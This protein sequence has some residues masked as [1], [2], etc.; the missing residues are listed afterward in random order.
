MSVSVELLRDNVEPEDIALFSA[1]TLT[2]TFR[3]LLSTLVGVLLSFKFPYP[4]FATSPF[5]SR[6][7]ACLRRRFVRQC[8]WTRRLIWLRL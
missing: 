1:F 2:A 4:D 3:L 7:T 5:M 8:E 6:G